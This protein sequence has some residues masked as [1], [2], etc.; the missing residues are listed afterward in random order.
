MNRRI[1]KKLEKR[2]NF[3]HYN[4]YNKYKYLFGTSRPRQFI[5]SAKHLL[6]QQLV[7]KL[8]V[9]KLY[10]TKPDIDNPSITCNGIID[11]DDEY[12]YLCCNKCGEKY[13]F[14]S[15]NVTLHHKPRPLKSFISANMD[16]DW[17]Y[18]YNE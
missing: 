3:R 8:N 12:N 6:D 10:C 18:K 2:L 9:D 17:G 7:Y 4:S 1:K 11:Y 13:S 14:S 5:L 15:L 16:L